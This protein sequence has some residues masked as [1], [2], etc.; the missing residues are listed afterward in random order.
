MCMNCYMCGR[1][2]KAEE[3]VPEAFHRAC[4]KCGTEASGD[5]KECR[6]CGA[7]LPPPLPDMDP[8]Q[9]VVRFD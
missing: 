9:K 7:A 3:R 5:E 1:C 6:N 8:G 4:F 2:S